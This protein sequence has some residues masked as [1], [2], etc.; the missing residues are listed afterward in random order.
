M[1]SAVGGICGG[2]ALS[3]L[4]PGIGKE[5]HLGSYSTHMGMVAHACSLS[6]LKDQEF[7]SV[8]TT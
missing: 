1:G 7:K 6:T 8:W 4:K 2:H 5:L 3:A